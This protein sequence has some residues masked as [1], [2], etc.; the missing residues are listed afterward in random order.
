MSIPSI[1]DIALIGAD[2][3]ITFTLL[4]GT[5]VVLAASAAAIAFSR[6]K[7]VLRATLWMSSF[8]VLVLAPAAMMVAP[9]WAAPLIAFP[10]RLWSAAALGSSPGFGLANVPLAGWFF[11]L[12]LAVAL[13][14]LARL[15]LDLRAAARISRRALPVSDE[16]TVALLER[17]RHALRVATPVRLLC[18]HEI[19]GPVS[20]GWRR[21]TVL[22]PTG[23]EAWPS[24]R[25]WAVLLH[26]VAHVRRRDWPVMIACEIVR[27]LHWVNPLVGWL[28]HRLRVAQD[29]ACDALSIRLGRIRPE[30]YARHLVD[31][32]RTLRTDRRV[33]AA[34]PLAGSN[35]LDAR[36]R[37]IMSPARRTSAPAI[38]AAALLTLLFG[39]GLAGAQ[40]WRCD[41]DTPP[42]TT[43]ASSLT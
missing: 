2:M 39:F 1:T 34:L 21:P 38:V 15:C 35:G 17:A 16:G 25:L 11:A 41:A 31:V 36:V 19:A 3:V 5:L 10:Q 28:A 18:S 14:L 9:S 12:W 4:K 23:S 22:L 32:A 7:P 27:A 40:L 29:R 13:F 42:D 20:L 8:G 24:D 37:A 6:A 33:A 30:E 43:A 26:E